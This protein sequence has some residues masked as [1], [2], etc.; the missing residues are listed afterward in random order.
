MATLRLFKATDLFRIGNINLDMY[1]ENY[2]ISFYLGYMA[3][4]PEMTCIAL[5]HTSTPMGYVIG[6]MEGS[7]SEWHGHVSALTVAPEFR[8]LGIADRLMRLLEECSDQYKGYFVDLF[9]RASN[10]VAIAMYNRFGYI[11]Y[12]RVLD[13]Y[14]GSEEGP[15]QA[16]DALDMRKSLSMDPNKSCM[17]PCK[18]PVTADQVYYE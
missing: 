15:I 8:R 18:K 10:Q 3:K 1:T 4:W 16:E 7:G 13:Y 14:S 17:I 12:R 9:V 6:R 11:T 5:S 2:Q